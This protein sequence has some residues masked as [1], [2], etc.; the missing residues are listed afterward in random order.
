MPR[1]TWKSVLSKCKWDV[2]F[3][4][5]GAGYDCHMVQVLHHRVHCA[6]RQLR[7]CPSTDL[8]VRECRCCIWVLCS[9]SQLHCH[10]PNARWS[11]LWGIVRLGPK[12]AAQFVTAVFNTLISYN[13]SSCFPCKIIFGFANIICTLWWLDMCKSLCEEG[14]SSMH[15]NC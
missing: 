6:A 13:Q 4:C 9:T 8:L 1:K 15:S 12:F 5:E 11:I 10:A 3:S 2:L 14:A 7:H